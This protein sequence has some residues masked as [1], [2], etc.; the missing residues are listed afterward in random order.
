MQ[1]PTA[2]EI[3]FSAFRDDYG[4][5]AH[6]VFENGV[7]IGAIVRLPKRTFPVPTFL[8]N[9]YRETRASEN[10]TDALVEVGSLKEA[11]ARFIPGARL[12]G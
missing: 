12:H 6:A 1:N 9:D 8:V 11:K 2:A 5:S 3:T 4:R 10:Y 7:R